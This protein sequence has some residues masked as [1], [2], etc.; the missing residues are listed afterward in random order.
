MPLR[1]NLYN[2]RKQHQLSLLNREYQILYNKQ[3][4]CSK[5]VEG[6]IKLFNRNKADIIQDIVSYNLPPLLTSKS[7][8]QPSYDYLLNIPVHAFSKERLDALLNQCSQI[9]QEIVKWQNAT[10]E[11][12]WEAE[13]LTLRSAIDPEFYK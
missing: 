11:S 4:F 3:V 5:V 8:D 9:Q 2:K 1:E 12:I 10:I 13:L 6:S 7:A